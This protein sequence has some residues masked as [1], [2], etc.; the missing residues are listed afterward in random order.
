M[1]SSEGVAGWERLAAFEGGTVT[2]L[3]TAQAADGTW[4]VF[5]ATPVGVFRSLDRGLSWS[6]LGGASR[7]AG[8]E[9]VVASPR[10]AEDGIVFAGAY[11]GLFRWWQGGTSWEHLLSGSRV[12]SVA[13]SPVADDGRADGSGL[14]VL[15]GT[16][17]DGI[18]VT[19]DGGRSWTG[20]NAGLQDLEILAL[21]LSPRFG[22]DRL[23][24]AATSSGLY[25]SRNGAESWRQVDLEWEDA[26]IQCLAISP[27][28][29]DTRVI[30][31]GTE[32]YGLLRSDDAG[33]SWESMLASRMVNALAY[34][35]HGRV[36]A[37]TDGGLA[38][39]D[40]EGQTW[41]MVGTDLGGVGGVA[42]LEDGDGSILLAGL[43]EMWAPTEP[44]LLHTGIGRSTDGGQTWAAA[45]RGLAAILLTEL[46]FAPDFEANR[47][48]LAGSLGQ[49]VRVSR[50]GGRTW[51]VPDDAHDE[52][53][54]AAPADNLPRPPAE[55][56]DVMA[57]ERSPS[58]E[59]DGT[60]CAATQGRASR[61]GAPKT[62]VW[63]TVDR[64]QHWDAW[65]TLPDVPGGTAVRVVALPENRYEDSVVVG[66]GNR[67][68]RPRRGSWERD[69][70]ARRA[71]WDA[72]E[73][74]GSDPAGR[75][76]T[77]A[78]LAA[79]P[80]Y[81]QDRT[82]FAASSAGVYVSRDGGASFTAWNDG[83]EPLATVA[84]SPSPAYARD[85]LVYG[86][87]LGGTVWRRRDA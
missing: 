10:Y 84:V 69:G 41:Q 83:L 29:A 19:R 9:V 33:R 40:D 65:L 61:D 16:E 32:E 54:D 48:L 85:R 56:A 53:Q 68:L 66:L 39:S 87:G 49:V 43:P 12:L 47:T 63:R 20:A 81:A 14:I 75:L 60:A 71:V 52:D 26:A 3:A 45:N 67:V 74:P 42:R 80:D 8:A 34:D 55:L 62:V 44:G 30:L 37:A 4:H 11:D 59:R 38:L 17:T 35:S 50:D 86:L 73:L 28:F 51:A 2:S 21:T 72:V 57:I 7:V 36:V 58:Y 76:P 15:A 27:S 18:L 5:A 46:T 70:G 6:P 82:L 24:F 77:I 78:R 23:A 31:A 79:S 13:C 64:G 22:Q 1:T 25:R